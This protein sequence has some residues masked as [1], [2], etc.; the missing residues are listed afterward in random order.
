V[1]LEC[2]VG[3]WGCGV[4]NKTNTG[5]LLCSVGFCFFWAKRAKQGRDQ[6]SKGKMSVTWQMYVDYIKAKGNVED[7]MI[8]DS[9]DCNHWAGTPDFML[10]EYTATIAQEDGT[11][12]EET[13]NEATNLIKLM[14][15]QGRPAQG[16]RLN[17]GK[18]QQI[19]RAFQDEEAN[20]FIVY[21]KV[22]S[23]STSFILF[24]I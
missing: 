18:K 3:V 11:D 16:L 10:R 2:G 24:L 22:V 21:G 14:S 8:V 13:V 9:E 6:K 4:F 1:A 17:G 5:R 7:V 15:G 23:L 20:T 19:L 12:K